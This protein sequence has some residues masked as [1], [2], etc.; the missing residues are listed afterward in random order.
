MQKYKTFVH[1][2][3]LVASVATAFP[4][5]AGGIDFTKVDAKKDVF[6]D[7]PG[8][9]QPEDTTKLSSKTACTSSVE[10]LRIAPPPNVRMPVRV[11]TC[12]DGFVTIQSTR[13]PMEYDWQIYKKRLAE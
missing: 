2:A 6:K 9:K 7:L 1:A 11:Y 8:V 4:A 13:P 10:D 3:L 12:E 5:A